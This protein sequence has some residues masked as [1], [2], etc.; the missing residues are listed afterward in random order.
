LVYNTARVCIDI[1]CRYNCRV[2][3][4]MLTTYQKETYRL[5][6]SVLQ[7]ARQNNDL[8]SLTVA[9]IVIKGLENIMNNPVEN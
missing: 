4:K 3:I 9:S 2:E 6:L 7:R 8:L 5:A 1:G